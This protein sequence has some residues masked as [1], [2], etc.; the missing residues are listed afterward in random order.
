[1]PA[2]PAPEVLSFTLPSEFDV[3]E[4]VVAE[5]ERFLEERLPDEDLAYRIVLLATEAVTNAI[6]HGNRLDAAKQVRMELSVAPEH[7]DLW[8]EDEGGGFEPDRI[9]DPL[10]AENL[11]HT[12]GRGVYL[13][14]QMADEVRFE[15]GGRRV[16]MRFHR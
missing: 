14:E 3:L 16:S 1:M 9:D 6:E 2:N 13:I 15:A 10:D 5:T 7:V 8:V 4:R 11:L 12:R